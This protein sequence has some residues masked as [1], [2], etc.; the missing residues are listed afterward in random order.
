MTL[1]EFAAKH[2]LRI[3][4]PSK[5]YQ[6]GPHPDRPYVVGKRG[7]IT[8]CQDGSMKLFV[9]IKHVP[10]AIEELESVG[11]ETQGRGDHELMARFH[12]AHRRQVEIVLKLIQARRKRQLTPE[13]KSANAARLAPY[14]KG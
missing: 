3:K 4:Q 9:A 12:P 7:W 5:V 11:I 10:T 1:K 14:R 2:H 8:E 6:P 13:Q